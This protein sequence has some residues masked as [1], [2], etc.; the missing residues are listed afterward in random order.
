MLEM[1]GM[2]LMGMGLDG[3]GPGDG[4]FW[5][6]QNDAL[7]KADGFFQSFPDRHQAVLMLDGKGAVIAGHPQGGNEVAPEA[8][9]RAVSHGAED[10]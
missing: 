9:G 2:V 7:Q 6:L 5:L 4:S 1:R 3:S 10:P 8:A